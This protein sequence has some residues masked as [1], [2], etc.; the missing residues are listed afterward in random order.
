MG[1]FAPVQHPRSRHLDTRSHK[2]S[3]AVPS[4]SSQSPI[5]EK[6]SSRQLVNRGRLAPTRRGMALTVLI[7]NT[8]RPAIPLHRPTPVGPA[9]SSTMMSRAGDGAQ[10]GEEPPLTRGGEVAVF[11]PASSPVV[12]SL[13]VG[14]R[15]SRRGSFLRVRVHD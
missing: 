14:L 10:Y 13:W 8:L 15:P 4:Y 11:R 3:L 1:R 5:S 7:D 9:H 6:T 12:G 2:N